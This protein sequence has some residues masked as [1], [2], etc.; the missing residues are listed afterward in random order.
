[1]NSY[2]D[3]HLVQLA[4]EG[5]EDAIKIIYDKYKPIIIKKSKTAFASVKH[6]GIDVNDII[7]ECYIALD[8]AINKYNQNDSAMFYTFALLCI[9][10]RIGG[11]LRRIKRYKNKILNDAVSIDDNIQNEISYNNDIL[12]DIVH[13]NEN[14]NLINMIENELTSF[15]KS[16]FELKLKGLEFVEI[17]KILHKDLKSIYNAF[18]RIKAKYKKIYKIDD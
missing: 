3:Y 12:D 16:V 6:H 4:Q 5:N 11:Y 7:Q 2:N 14:S 1:M 17:S 15:E 8:D 18:N 9:E 10:R 13:E